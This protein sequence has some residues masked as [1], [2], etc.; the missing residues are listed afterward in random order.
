MA[1]TYLNAGD[2][3]QA[4]EWAERAL[5]ASE[6]A[7]NSTPGPWNTRD[8]IL[9][10]ASLRSFKAI[11]EGDPWHAVSVLE[12][13]SHHFDEESS[14]SVDSTEA[15]LA[16]ATVW[17]PGAEVDPDRLRRSVTQGQKWDL[18]PNVVNGHS[19]LA[20]LAA[21]AGD[22]ETALAH[23]D[24]ALS[25][26][27][28][29]EQNRFHRPAVAHL[30]RG[31]THRQLGRLADAQFAL[32]E[33]DPISRLGRLP[34]CLARVELERARI[35]HLLGQREDMLA[36]IGRARAVLSE[37]ARPD[38]LDHL[39]RQVENETRFAP[40]DDRHLPIGAR[41]LTE[42]ELTVIRLLPAGLP[43]RELAEQLHIS[44]NTVKTHLVSIRRKLGL[45]GREDIVAKAEELGLQ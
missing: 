33:A 41:E 31:I 12:S 16:T 10:V 25:L 42:R 44:E 34:L 24:A 32:D 2:Y 19:H 40:V 11:H 29:E 39:V 7:D 38:A 22:T 36:A 9:Q 8:V 18:S 45:Q 13:V 23:A 21:D 20:L 30:A 28:T 43:R 5:V 3:Q 26:I 15:A 14:P 35:L 1:W 6:L 37:C 27:E 17:L 4:E